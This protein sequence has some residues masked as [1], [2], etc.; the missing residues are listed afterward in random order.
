MNEQ[1]GRATPAQ[2]QGVMIVSESASELKTI[3]DML[4]DMQKS[5][6]YMTKLLESLVN[7]LDLSDKSKTNASKMFEMQ[8]ELMQSLFADKDF[9]GK[10]KVME[11]F[12]KI[13][14]MGIN[15]VK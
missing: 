8:T 7:H 1:V 10:D 5:L 12:E 4:S 14:E 2:N 13:K 15:N 11:V 9:K 3:K 6:G